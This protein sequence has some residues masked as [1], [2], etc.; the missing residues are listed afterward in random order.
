MA[1]Q[2]QLNQSINKEKAAL[3][4]LLFLHFV[5][6]VAFYYPA[7]FLSADFYFEDITHF[8]EPHCRFIGQTLAKGE[9]PLWNPLSYCGM[10]QAAV[11]SPGIFFPFNWLFAFLPFSFALALIM[12]VHQL[13]AGV[14]VYFYARFFQLP[15]AGCVFAGSVICFSGYLFGFQNN[16]TLVATA[17][18]LSC[19]MTAFVYLSCTVTMKRNLIFTLLAVISIYMTIAGGRPEIFVP[20]FALLF[21]QSAALAFRLGEKLSIDWPVVVRL[22]RAFFIGVLLAMPAILPAAE[23]VPWSRRAEGLFAG[24]V[25]L[26][27]AS[28]YDF[29]SLILLQP[30]GDLQRTDAPFLGLTMPMK[31]MPY[32]PSAYLGPGVCILAIWGVFAKRTRLVLVLVFMALFFAVLSAGA[33]LPGVSIVVESLN[34]LSLL[35]FPIK[36]LLFSVL[37]IAMLAALGA[38][39]LLSGRARVLPTVIFSLLLVFAGAVLMAS[40]NKILLPFEQ[41]FVTETQRIIGQHLIAQSLLVSGGIGLAIN[42]LAG[43]AKKNP[44]YCRL[45]F[46]TI[47]ALS[48]AGFMTNADI[49]CAKFTGKSFFSRP[50]E[51]AGIIAG[52]KN[53]QSQPST[54]SGRIM[55]FYMESF[56][57]PR[58]TIWEK[59][60]DADAYQYDRQIMF[61]NDNYDF[62]IPHV[63]GFEGAM[64]GEY[65]YYLLNTFIKSNLSIPKDQ[66]VSFVTEIK[67]KAQE[68]EFGGKSDLPL[69]R[70]LQSCSCDYVLTQKDT[71][72][73]TGKPVL[74]K[75]LDSRFF[76][77]VDEIKNLNLRLY[78]VKQTMPRAYLLSKFKVFESRDKLIDS[79][80]FAE[81]TGFSPEF[82]CLLEAKPDFEA[83]G[84]GQSGTVA[85]KI[86]LKDVSNSKVRVEASVVEPSIL[87]LT[88]QYYPGWKAIVDGTE[89]EL[90]R[91]NGFFRGV[92]LNPGAHEVVFTYEPASLRNAWLLV[93]CGLLW[94]ALWIYQVC[95]LPKERERNE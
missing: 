88:D 84:T 2:E 41:K 7:L 94:L 92:A 86:D 55:T 56:T 1:G 61:P 24:E 69:Y 82:E 73:V 76:E 89:Q 37:S 72:T 38:S 90:L 12:I 31:W 52:L 29:L 65:F 28:W 87:V 36:L 59:R 47:F 42:V 50:S 8:F 30:L 79:M 53:K 43:F 57:R 44:L 3:V 93:A 10:P 70:F 25:L 75:I 68:P 13:L 26:F 16:F 67:S 66:V 15:R 60:R 95:S 39:E 91:V 33:N 64:V 48:I 49:G 78:R 58:R 6:L 40:G 62:G 74:V 51:L 19:A 45:T 11:S 77:L 46:G 54:G 81:K 22:V 32:L 9:L 80:F 85:G 4:G 17:A 5:L 35:R 34:M 20:G 83:I 71:I 27:S 23:W 18:W 21:L 63:Y 14:S